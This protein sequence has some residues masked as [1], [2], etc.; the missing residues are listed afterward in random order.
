MYAQE[1]YTATLFEAMIILEFS[2]PA[3][4]LDLTN[5]GENVHKHQ[6]LVEKN[7]I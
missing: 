2:G 4:A 6:R 5:M 1:K 3:A 7:T